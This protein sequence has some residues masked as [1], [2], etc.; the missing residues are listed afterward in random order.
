MG[1]KRALP[2]SRVYRVLEPGPVVPVTTVGKGRPNVMPM[3]WHTMIDVEPPLVDECYANLTG[4][5]A[6]S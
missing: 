3:S 2:L 6:P 4:G 1:K 5:A